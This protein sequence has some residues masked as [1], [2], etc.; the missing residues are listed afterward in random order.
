[1]IPFSLLTVH[2]LG[3]ALLASF[4]PYK[5]Y[6]VVFLG[7][8]CLFLLLGFKKRSGWLAAPACFFVFAFAV[9]ILVNDADSD[10]ITAI[11][12]L[13][14][15][16]FLLAAVCAS[17]LKGLEGLEQRSLGILEKYLRLAIVLLFAQVAYFQLRA[18]GLQLSSDDS[19]QAGLIFVERNLFWGVAD[20]NILGAKIAIFGFL[21]SVLYY[22]VFRKIGIFFPALIVF[23]A[24]LSLSRT[25][26]LIYGVFGVIFFFYS[27]KIGPRA[28]IAVL[29]LFAVAAALFILPKLADFFRLS[30]IT[31][32]DYSDGMGLRLIYWIAL[33]SNLD[34]VSWHGNGILSGGEFL[35]RYAA[36]YNG[37]PNLHNIFLNT[38]LDL[39]FVGLLLYG[40]IWVVYYK[41]LR[42]YGLKAAVVG[43]LVAP[44][45]MLVNSLY[46]AYDSDP[47]IYMAVLFIIV[48]LDARRAAP[49]LGFSN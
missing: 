35:Q 44:L 45:F 13:T 4:V 46:T 48:S 1:M 26:S 47:W 11:V 12:K 18:G 9:F 49:Q 15:N 25:S 36:Y 31:N 16:F 3:L 37:E 29:F 20:K 38:F 17:G 32:L 19:Y 5:I 23:S 40:S 2:A 27:L 14:V 8:G 7:T 24:L 28:K 10:N 30:S 33:F 42:Q 21:H 6:P 39:G 41:Q 43:F 22:K 34:Q